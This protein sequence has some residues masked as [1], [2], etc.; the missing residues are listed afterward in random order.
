MTT[1][2]EWMR[3]N[4]LS[5][6]Q[7]LITQDIDYIIFSND[8]KSFVILEEKNSEWAKVGPAQAVI[9]KFLDEFLSL[10]SSVQF[11]GCFLVYALHE[12]NIYINPKIIRQKNDW[13]A[14]L[15]GSPSISLNKLKNLF[16][17]KQDQLKKDYY[18]EWWNPIIENSKL[19]DCKDE[20]SE[21][22]TTP[23]RT[24]Y[25][26]TNLC[27]ICSNMKKV[28]WIFVN[29]CTGYF[30]LL[31]ERTFSDGN[32]KPNPHERVLIQTI[33]DIF[34][35]SN[36]LNL[37]MPKVKNPKSE[38]PYQYLGYFLIEFDKNIPDDS[39]NIWLNHKQIRL[40]DLKVFLNL[41]SDKALEIVERY[42]KTW[43]EP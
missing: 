41:D 43:W 10:Q 5:S 40:D 23:E 37:S 33:N 27:N 8:F 36:R 4:L 6:W 19:Y 14:D 26:G 9:F 20:P 25:R 35:E 11:Y 12:G 24:R 15:K 1:F 13:I 7:G 42:K 22:K 32:Y 17:N 2:S 31:E 16:C 21:Y 38:K 34:E 39:Q 29:Y 3:D 28:H 30:I 18:A